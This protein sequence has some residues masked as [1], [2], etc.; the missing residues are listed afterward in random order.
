MA[1][2]IKFPL[3]MTDGTDV[4]TLEELKEHFD[5]K[6]V[7]EYY[8]SGKLLTWLKDRYCDIEAGKLSALSAENPDFRKQLCEIFGI[9]LEEEQHQEIDMELIRRRN[10]KKEE[11]LKVTSDAE[12]LQNIDSVA[13]NQEDLYDCL[14]S[15][16]KKIYLVSD[17]FTVP[18]SVPDMEYIG[19]NG[20]S[21]VI[22]AMDNENFTEKNLKFTDM[23]FVWDT[24]AITE[25]DEYWIAEQYFLKG[26]HEKAEKILERLDTPKTLVL[27]YLIYI[28][29][30][31]DLLEDEIYHVKQKGCNINCAYFY[32]ENNLPVLKY[33]ADKGS[34][35]D[36]FI[37]AYFSESAE[38]FQKA[39][40]Q[41]AAFLQYYYS[42]YCFEHEMYSEAVKWTCK[43]LE[44]GCTKADLYD[45]QEEVSENEEAVMCVQ[46]MAEE[47]NAVAQY[48]YAVQCADEDEEKA[49]EWLQKSAEQGYAEAQGRLGFICSEIK[50]D[51]ENAVKW[52]Y[53]AAEQGHEG[54]LNFLEEYLSE[55]EFIILIMRIAEKGYTSIQEA[56]L[57]KLEDDKEEYVSLFRESIKTENMQCAWLLEEAKAE[58]PTAQYFYSVYCSEKKDYEQAVKWLIAFLEQGES[59]TAAELCLCLKDMEK[60][61]PYLVDA[62]ESEAEIAFEIIAGYFSFVSYFNESEPDEEEIKKYSDIIKHFEDVKNQLMIAAEQDNSI[63]VLGLAL[64]EESMEGVQKAAELGLTIAKEISLSSFEDLSDAEKQKAEEWIPEMA[65]QGDKTAQFLLGDMY[66]KKKEYE[67]AVEWYRKS[68]QQGNAQAQNA[69]GDC[70]YNGNGVKDYAEAVKWYRKAAEQGIVNAQN[71]LGNCC[72]NG[73]G[74]SQNYAE[75]FKWYQKAAEQ[76]NANAQ[77]YLGNCY[78]NGYSVPQN[79]AESFKWYQKSAEQGDWNGQNAIGN[80]YYNG[81]GVSQNYAE[82]VKWYQKSA[83]QGHRYAQDSLADCFQNGYGVNKDYNQAAK[84]Y[85]KAAENGHPDSQNYLGVFYYL[86]RGVP[87]NYSKAVEWFTKAAENGSSWGCYNLANAYYNGNGVS[88]NYAEAVKWYQKSAEQGN[89]DAQNSLGNCYYNGNG[90][91]Q[92]YTEAVKW[93]QKSAE[94][95]NM[96][97]QNNLANCYYN[98]KGT[99]QDYMYAWHWYEQSAAQG[100]DWAQYNLGNCYYYGHGVDANTTM[101][102]NWY[103][104]A[105]AQGNKDAQNQ[106]QA[107]A[108]RDASW[109][110]V[111]DSWKDVKNAFRDLFR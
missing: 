92:N 7:L 110:D 55:E 109:D 40:E 2:K 72:Y 94:Q 30:E 105:A 80:C 65:E 48:F 20:A 84:W 86:G 28:F 71:S 104:K 102:E 38:Y 66:F 57:E 19:I 39:A 77:F 14:D 18:L 8:T 52:M 16:I 11:L 93:Y 61:I 76:G 26:E 73:K 37:Y 95:G 88:Q 79:Y 56:L 107:L 10:E 50:Q 15:G 24:S 32:S 83:E 9:S 41:G 59:V 58:N 31:D 87:Q 22:R 108:S 25:K 82:A 63:A 23:C 47:G 6:S 1:K 97:A 111:R 69:L 74:T 75:A 64:A 5:L 90:I 3:R 45:I 33:M 21:A 34:I 78:Y 70:Y 91:S 100:Y 62:P 103:R 98:G 96:Y 54:A 17:I 81:N 42:E 106:L 99:P 4:R 49:L 101:A 53:A 13:L 35:L 12:L 46:K 43:A 68:A 29:S 27:L 67:N 44:Q 60:A 89:A 36:K 85:E 51:N